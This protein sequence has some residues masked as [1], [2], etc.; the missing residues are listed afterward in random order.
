M[1]KDGFGSV[2]VPGLEAELEVT[3]KF[4]ATYKAMLFG[5]RSEKARL[6]LGDQPCLD[7]GDLSEVPLTLSAANDDPGPVQGGHRGCR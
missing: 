2:C 4:L 5:A 3:R 1:R 7:L 6:V